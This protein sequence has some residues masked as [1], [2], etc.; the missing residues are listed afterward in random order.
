MNKIIEAYNKT[1]EF[2]RLFNMTY[3]IVKPGEVV[4]KLLVTQKLLATS[5]AMHGGALAGMMDAV[6]GVTALSVSSLKNKVVSTVEFKI[7]YLKPVFEGDELRGVGEV[8]SEGNRIIVCKGEIFNQNQELVAIATAT[9]NA[10]PA[11]KL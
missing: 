1:N 2:G 4:Y 7:N 5:K 9:L 6:V 10:Y 11:N 8:I 3:T